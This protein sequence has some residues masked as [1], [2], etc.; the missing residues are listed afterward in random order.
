MENDGLKMELETT[1]NLGNV[2]KM[3]LE[4]ETRVNVHIEKRMDEMRTDI[5]NRFVND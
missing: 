2:R 3:L 5:F 1:S 4:M